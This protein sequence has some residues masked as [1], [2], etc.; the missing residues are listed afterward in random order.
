MGSNITAKSL[1][2]ICLLSRTF[3]AFEKEHPKASTLQG[4]RYQI[5]QTYWKNK[6]W[7][8]TREWL[9][10]IIMKAASKIAG[11]DSA[12]RRLKESRTLTIDTRW[13]SPRRTSRLT[14]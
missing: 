3:L 14:D 4:F 5:A 10:K 11:R 8:K 1:A 6:Q 9:N 12:E 7:A 13:M 2:N